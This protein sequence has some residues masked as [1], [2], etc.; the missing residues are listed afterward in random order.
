M[1]MFNKLVYCADG[2]LCCC[3]IA[4]KPNTNPVAAQPIVAAPQQ[5]APAP[6]RQ[7]IKLDWSQEST[8]GKLLVSK[9]DAFFTLGHYCGLLFGAL[10]C[11]YMRTRIVFVDL[12]Q[13]YD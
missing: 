7:P 13:C 2:L 8:P 6:I 12:P 5:Q 9:H 10:S 11:V 3:T 1:L 4:A